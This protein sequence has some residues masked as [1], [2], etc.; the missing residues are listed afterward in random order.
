MKKK[1]PFPRPYI[2]VPL[3]IDPLHHGHI[4]ILLKAKKY[5]K[6]IVVGLMT[7]KAIK[8]YKKRRSVIKFRDRKKILKHL[9]CVDY[10]IPLKNINF[11]SVAEK[12]KFDYWVH[13]TDWKKGAQSNSR[14]KLI[15]AMKKWNGKVIEIPYTKGISSSK[16]KKILF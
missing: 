14:K 2:C 3:T 16:I 15:K 7:D 12:Y 9:D 10:V 5:G 11:A 1:F 8:N 13:G 4:N 6:K